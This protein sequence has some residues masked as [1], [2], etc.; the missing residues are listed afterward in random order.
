MDDK[1]LML[2]NIIAI[3]LKYLDLIGIGGHER[4]TGETEVPVYKPSLITTTQ[5]I[6]VAQIL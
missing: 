5:T 6:R 4:V 1:L 3:C 2:V